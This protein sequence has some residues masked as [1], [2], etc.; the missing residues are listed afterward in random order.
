MTLTL[1][2]LRHVRFPLL[3]I[4]ALAPIPLAFAQQSTPGIDAQ[5]R[6]DEQRQQ[7]EQRVAERPSVLAPSTEP[8]SIDLASLPLDTPC[9]PIRTLQL[10]GNPFDWLDALLQPVVG[11]CVGA[12]AIQAIQD[13]ANN[14][15]IERGFVTSR[16]LIPQQDLAS[17][18]LRLTVLA[19]RVAA[20]KRDPASGSEIGWSRA[21]LPAYPGTL[22]NQRDIDQALESVRRL[23][24]QAD[25]A[26]D[27][28][29]SDAPDAHPGDSIL[30]VKPSDDKRS[31]ATIGAD[32]YGLDTTGRY[33]LNGSFTFDSPLHL[34]DQL[35]LSG[36]TNA[37]FHSDEKASRSAALNWNVPVGYASLFVNA[38]RSRYVQSVAGYEEPLRYSGDSAELNAGVS[39]VPYR[40]ASART[41]TQFKL[42]HRLGHSFIDGQSLDVQ[43]RDLIGVETSASHQQYIG[44]AVLSGGVAWRQT[45]RGITHNPGTLTGSPD[46][47]GKTRIAT[48]NL[49]ASVPFAIGGQ[50]LRYAGQV[51][52]QHAYT[53][54]VPFDYL[55]IGSPY[56]VRGFDGQTTLAAESGW[57]W[58]NEL[59]VQIAGQTPFVAL[60]AGRVS[61]PSAPAL[62]GTTLVGTALGLR[63]RLPASRYAAIDYEI[64]LG[65]PL[66]KPRGFPTAHPALMFQ[67]TTL[68]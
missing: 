60:D 62:L 67:A 54:I 47:D 59:G 45:I 33:N 22:Y 17:G 1:L 52:W 6:Q 43:S 25:T 34:Y 30:V 68:F 2:S 11:Q 41:S 20:V 44:S 18:A 50:T 49:Q 31:H 35:T 13:A 15:L 16:V 66:V 57:T 4:V 36:S 53:R 9:F 7:T 64:T 61:G 10:D 24:G 23:S 26:F 12:S 56:T 21:V 40:S 58:R 32:N 5:R 19:G 27:V 51:N 29:P 39:Y 37:N 14:A 55:T 42:Y 63:G 46:W 28:T 8:R 38:S 3:T 48:A 65:W